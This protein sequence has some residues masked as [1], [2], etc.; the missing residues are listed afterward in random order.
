MLQLVLGS[1]FAPSIEQMGLC[2]KGDE[3]IIDIHSNFQKQS[4]RNRCNIFS[5]NG[6]QTLVVPVVKVSGQ[7]TPMKDV[8]IDYTENWIKDH[9]GALMSAYNSSA[10]Y[11]FYHDELFAI[12]AARPKKL[13]DLNQNLFNWLSEKTGVNAE[14]SFSSEYL[15][16]AGLPNFEHQLS[17]KHQS[18]L[19]F[20]EYP[21]VFSEKF[22]FAPN[23]SSLD[24]LFNLGP[25]SYT[26]IEQIAEQI[27]P[28]D[29][30]LGSQ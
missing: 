6:V 8:L 26:I 10:Y 15:G 28:L 9:L 7:K 3:V 23:L 14:L 25:E 30:E 21:Q 20:E 18:N 5:A 22:S 4:F 11:H 17:K 16:K 24:L 2:L 13:I 12:Y 29:Y 1:S 19:S 27:N